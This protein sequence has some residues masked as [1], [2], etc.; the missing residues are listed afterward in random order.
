M[1]SENDPKRVAG[2]RAAELVET[3]MVVGLGTGSTVY[4]TLVRLAE[5]IESEGLAIRGIPTSK[6][7]EGK[8]RALGIPLVA[9]MTWKGST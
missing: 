5:R 4:H 3:G 8:A 2:R 7:T 9:S 6:D 1:T